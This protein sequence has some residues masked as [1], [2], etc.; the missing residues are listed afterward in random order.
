MSEDITGGMATWSRDMNQGSGIPV[1]GVSEAL[2]TAGASF[3]ILGTIMGMFNNSGPPSTGD[4][5]LDALRALDETIEAL[6]REVLASID[7]VG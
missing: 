7:R 6:H 1:L 4:S 3:G 5:V 2:Q